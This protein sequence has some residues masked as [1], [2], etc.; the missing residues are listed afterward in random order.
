MCGR[1]KKLSIFLF[2]VQLTGKV[3]IVFYVVHRKASF[4]SEQ[5]S[6]VFSHLLSSRNSSGQLQDF[7]RLLFLE[8]FPLDWDEVGMMLCSLTRITL[9][10]GDVLNPFCNISTELYSQV[11]T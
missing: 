2:L 7:A 4:Q 11:C 1:R 10:P 6:D 5:T 3:I 9:C 8:L